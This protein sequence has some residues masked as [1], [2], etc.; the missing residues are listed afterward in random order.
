MH[1]GRHFVSVDPSMLPPDANVKIGSSR[2]HHAGHL[3]CPSV[4]ILM[5][6][7]LA[8]ANG[9]LQLFTPDA[10]ASSLDGN[11]QPCPLSNM[12]GNSVLHCGRENKVPTIEK[13]HLI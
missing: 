11:D 8:N 12:S 7:A 13:R 2:N 1:A 5:V 6:Q 10:A 3:E 9:C 4:H